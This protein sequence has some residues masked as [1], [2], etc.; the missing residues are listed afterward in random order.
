MGMARDESAESPG[1]IECHQSSHLEIGIGNVFHC[2]PGRFTVNFRWVP[3]QKGSDRGF[4]SAKGTTISLPEN[5][6]QASNRPCDFAWSLK[7]TV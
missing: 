5:L 1:P 4:D 7:F 2:L 3:R 6:Q